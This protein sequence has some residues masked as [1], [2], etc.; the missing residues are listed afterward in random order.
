LFDIAAFMLW[1]IAAI[2]TIVDL[3]ALR[4]HLVATRAELAE[5]RAE[6]VKEREQYRQ[7]L[8]VFARLLMQHHTEVL[9]ILRA[10]IVPDRASAE[11]QTST[12]AAPATPREPA[13]ARSQRPPAPPLAWEDPPCDGASMEEISIQS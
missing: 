11:V 10:N 13:V 1:I 12:E 4:A 7:R 3:H 6:A 9:G 5:E 8:M 2:V